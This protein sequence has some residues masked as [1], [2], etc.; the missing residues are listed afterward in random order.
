MIKHFHNFFEYKGMAAALTED[1]LVFGEHLV[2]IR[3]G[4][5][6]FTPDR[7]YGTGN[8][9]RLR[10]RHPKLQLDSYNMTS[11][12]YDTILQRTNWPQTFFKGKAVLECGC[13]VGPDTEILLSLG[14]RVLAVDLTNLD[15][16]LS[17]LGQNPD[18]CFVQADIAEMITSLAF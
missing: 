1:H 17:N 15:T 12:R 10:E 5:A 16:A 18:L 9:S 14:A 8:F 2:P 13:G 11:D 4:I 6:R 7:S 3:N